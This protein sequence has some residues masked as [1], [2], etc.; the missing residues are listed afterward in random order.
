[1]DSGGDGEGLEQN[2]LG[3][4]GGKVCGQA[5]GQEWLREAGRDTGHGWA[6][7]ECEV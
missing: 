2:D 4:C 6:G 3:V 5:G 7:L 1:M